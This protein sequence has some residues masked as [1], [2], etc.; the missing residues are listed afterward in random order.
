MQ[1]TS[2]ACKLLNP[3]MARGLTYITLHIMYSYTLKL[4]IEP[5]TKKECSLTSL[6]HD[7]HLGIV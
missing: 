5:T 6:T 4:Y 7:Y 3:R 2:I 1:N